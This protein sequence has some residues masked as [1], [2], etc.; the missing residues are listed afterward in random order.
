M[1][2][3]GND[4]CSTF[5]TL[6]QTNEV[7]TNS[8]STSLSFFTTVAAP[9]TTI[10]TSTRVC[11]FPAGVTGTCLPGQVITST[12]TGLTTQTIPV[13]VQVPV[14]IENVQTFFGTT[15]SNGVTPPPPPSSTPSP[16]TETIASSVTGD[17]GSVSV[18]VLTVISTPDPGPTVQPA[19]VGS[20]KSS[21]PSNLG[22]IIGGVV[23][24]I[25]GLAGIVVLVIFIMKRRRRW[26]DIFDKE[27]DNVIAHAGMDHHDGGSG[28]DV[29]EPKP[30]QY[31]LVGQ[32]APPPT[33]TSSTHSQSM[34]GNLPPGA[35]LGD[36]SY[37]PYT[38]PYAGGGGGNYT[39]GKGSIP[40]HMMGGG[41]NLGVAAVTSRPSTAGSTQPLR[42]GTGS[43]P[44]HGH[45]QSN[46]NVS[47][48][49]M[50]LSNWSAVSPAGTYNNPL[51][52]TIYSPSEDGTATSSGVGVGGIYPN[53]RAGSPMSYQEPPR[54]LHVT[55]VVGGAPQSPDSTG[56]FMLGGGGGGH[57]NLQVDGK[58]R[59]KLSAEPMPLVHTDGGRIQIPTTSGG[60]AGPSGGG[61]GG[62]P[63]GPSGGIGGGG[64]GPVGTAGGPGPSQA[65]PAYS[66]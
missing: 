8:I 11:S 28:G 26:D 37:S 25:L 63:S 52:S 46:S 9:T 17:N 57:Q 23:G 4:L 41:G 1:A 13:T 22:A 54:R 14:T 12:I 21:S 7:V 39:G 64:A 61:G 55:N 36:A 45:T 42:P 47:S 15:C 30:Y 44:S 19:T 58:G 10:F 43:T 53:N 50:S 33:F 65:P 66:A 16:S 24:G 35:G 59:I 34:K 20:H 31:G 29:V 3:N 40:P 56:E 48:P 5:P 32:V 62:G 51:P 49:P 38:D 60:G 2:N 27:D 18:V 6:T